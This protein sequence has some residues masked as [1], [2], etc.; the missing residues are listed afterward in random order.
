MVESACF[1]DG[2]GV[3]SDL[4]RAGVEGCIVNVFSDGFIVGV[5]SAYGCEAG[6]VFLEDFHGG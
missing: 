3:F 6:C 4:F 2:G 1:D 5:V